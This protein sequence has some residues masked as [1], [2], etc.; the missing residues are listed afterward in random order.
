M[1]NIEKLNYVIVFL[2]LSHHK[3]MEEWLTQDF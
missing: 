3:Q 2:I 1:N